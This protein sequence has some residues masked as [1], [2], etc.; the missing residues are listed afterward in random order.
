[1]NKGCFLRRLALVQVSFD[2]ES[3]SE[4]KK[5]I[6]ES[7]YLEDLDIS[8]NFLQPKMVQPLLEA[9]AGNGRL[10]NLNLSWNYLIKMP[11]A[12]QAGT[13]IKQELLDLGKALP[14]EMIA[15]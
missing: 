15:V 10:K 7:R 4:L 9:I 12:P 13:Y 8:F 6:E 1:M 5:F 11:S 3:I 2:E 14:S